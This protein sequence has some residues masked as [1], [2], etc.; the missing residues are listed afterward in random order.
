MHHLKIRHIS[1]YSEHYN[2]FDDSLSLES[3]TFHECQYNAKS[4]AF[5]REE[6]KFN[7]TKN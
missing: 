4:L 7:T 3:L 1:E 2:F 6:N 5:S